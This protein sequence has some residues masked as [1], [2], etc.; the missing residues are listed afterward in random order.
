MPD[1]RIL[2]ASY[3][4][5]TQQARRVISREI[6]QKLQIYNEVSGA[7]LD[8]V[9]QKVADRAIDVIVAGSSNFVLLKENFPS[10]PIIPIVVSGLDLLEALTRACSFS[11]HVALVSYKGYLAWDKSYPRLFKNRVEFVSY[12]KRDNLKSILQTLKDKGCGCVIG[13]SLVC[14]LAEEL[15]L[16]TVFIYSKNSLTNALQRAVELQ[17]SIEK[18]QERNQQLSLIL[19]LIPSGIIAINRHREITLYNDSA[20]KL[21]GVPVTDAVGKNIVDVLPNTRLPEVMASGKVE[22]NQLQIMPNSTEILTNRAPIWVKD[23]VK[24][25]LATFNAT[26]EITKAE[27]KIRLNLHKKGLVARRTFDDL[28]GSSKVISEARRLAKIYAKEDATVLLTG[29]TGTG[30]ELFAQSIHNWSGRKGEPFVAINCAALSEDLLE[31]ELFGYEE[32]AFTGARKGGKPGLLELGHRGTVFLDEIGRISDKVQSRLLRVLEEKEIMRVGSD[33]VIPV[34]IRVIAASN[35]SLEQEIEKGRLR[36]DLYYRLNVMHISIPPL[37]ER[38]E[39]LPEILQVILKQEGKAHLYKTYHRQFHA[40]LERLK[41][42]DWPGNVREFR[43][44]IQRLCLVFTN[45]LDMDFAFR[46]IQL[47]KKE[48]NTFAGMDRETIQDTLK[49][50]GGNKTRTAKLLNVSR[51]TLWRRMKQLGLDE[52]E[53]HEI[54]R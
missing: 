21:T 24:G 11:D 12:S 43:N 1:K 53:T 7:I 44:V 48:K 16:T 51:T 54:F 26:D 32:G 3:P 8:I 31:S 46:D 29:E 42:Y 19:N 37:R 52:G 15:N 22:K 23:H 35:V 40:A 34:D 41:D 9:R 36:K 45:D 30:K 10:I 49:K 50:T 20:A 18:E 28:V 47:T 17:E 25:A 4:R 27:R 2:F 14:D 5:L 6:L 38:K 33:K 39:D 13:S